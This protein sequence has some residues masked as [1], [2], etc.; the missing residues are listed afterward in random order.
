MVE[1]EERS[2]AGTPALCP[3]FQSPGLRVL[4][5]NSKQLSTTHSSHFCSSPFSFLLYINWNMILILPNLPLQG[6]S[7]AQGAKFSAP[8]SSHGSLP[9]CPPLLAPQEVSQAS[10]GQ[11]RTQVST[12][13]C[14]PAVLS[15]RKLYTEIQASL[16]GGVL[17][18]LRAEGGGEARLGTSQ[19]HTCEF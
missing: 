7:I 13:K 3:R 8:A 18:K 17:S 4:G 14:P 10:P 16:G 9:N 12:A 6:S 5:P 15:L 2:D 1:E 19:V 11:C